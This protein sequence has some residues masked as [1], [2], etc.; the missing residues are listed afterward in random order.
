MK[1]MK[2]E[3]PNK[4]LIWHRWELVKDT[5]ATEYHKCKDCG[6]RFARSTSGGYQP[7][8]YRWVTGLDDSL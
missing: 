4:C 1:K 7:I 2:M 8:N 6:A 5:G 3:P